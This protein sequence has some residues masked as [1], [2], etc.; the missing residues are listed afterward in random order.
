MDTSPTT[1]APVLTGKNAV[2][3]GASGSVGS[4]L[5]APARAA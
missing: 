4:A 5:A 3:F 1:H 2:L